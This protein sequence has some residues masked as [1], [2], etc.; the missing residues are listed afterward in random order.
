MVGQRAL[1]VGALSA[2]QRRPTPSALSSFAAR[3]PRASSSTRAGGQQAAWL[4]LEH[5]LVQARQQHGRASRERSAPVL[6]PGQQLEPAHARSL[7]GDQ[8]GASP[9][10]TS[11][12]TDAAGGAGVARTRRLTQSCREV[13]PREAWSSVPKK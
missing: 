7:G 1:L 2:P 9:L 5:G 13:R 3:L 4:G 8:A 10:G 6:R 12:V 11:L